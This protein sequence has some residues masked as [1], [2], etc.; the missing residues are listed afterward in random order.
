MD[1]EG[2]S[3]SADNAQNVAFLH[4]QEVFAI[5][6][7]FGSRP[8]AEQD[9]ITGL[10]VERGDLAV[11]GARAVASS[12][13]FAFLRLFLGRIGDND[14]AGGLFLSLYTA[15]EDPVVE[16]T[17]L[18]TPHLSFHIYAAPPMLFR[19]LSAS[20]GTVSTQPTRVPMRRI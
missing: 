18:H 6:A 7:N 1:P 15:N 3:G 20:L 4:D 12:D 17:K 13:H 11:F 10:D 16:R 19:E 2:V 5:E 9:A 14:S 8:F